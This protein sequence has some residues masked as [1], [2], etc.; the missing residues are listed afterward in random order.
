MKRRQFILGLGAA[1]TGGSA[2]I[3]SGA[4]TSVAAERDIAVDV[5]GDEDAFLRLGPCRDDE[6]DAKPNGA[7]VD[8]TDGLL[9]ISLSDDNSNDQP[10]GSGVNPEALSKFHNVFEI[11][12]QGTQSVC[13]NF[14]VDDESEVP[15]IPSDAD[16]PERYDFEAGEDPAVIFY[17]SDSEAAV[18]PVEESDP[19]APEAIELDVGE[20][21]C[22]GFNVRAFGFESGEDIF[23]GT[24]LTIIADAEAE[25][26]EIEEPPACAVLQGGYSCTGYGDE[27]DFK[28]ATESSFS[29][30][31]VGDASTEF[32]YAVINDPGADSSNGIQIAPGE[33]EDIDIAPP[34]P[35][36]GL[37]FWSSDGVECAP[38]WGEQKD[39]EF[40]PDD[41][42]EYAEDETSISDEDYFSLLEIPEDVTN[43]LDDEFDGKLDNIPD[44]E[45]PEI[46]EEYDV[47]ACV[48]VD[49]PQ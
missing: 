37:V 40:V 23:A 26:G 30:E 13:V 16:V 17:E 41:L 47:T 29:V 48:S 46:L 42:K 10:A 8:T 36:A 49:E 3:G 7:Y 9:S 20:C 6:G 44:E 14:G 15:L 33:T 32:G 25:C 1:S 2:L 21:A 39:A 31:N 24:D 11:C 28:N 34:N 22:F 12:N 43:T 27:G 4:F 45:F 5:V 19:E 35:H 38:T 18:F